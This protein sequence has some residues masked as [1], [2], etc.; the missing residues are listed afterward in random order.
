M[1]I[2]VWRPAI[3]ESIDGR[4]LAQSVSELF[5]DFP[6]ERLP[7]NKFMAFFMRPE[8]MVVMLIFYLVSKPLLKRIA[9]LIDPKA[10]WLRTLIAI[11]NLGLAIFSA[12]VVWN[13]WPAVFFHLAEEGW[14]S[15]YCDRT[16]T[17]WGT[18]GFG[19]WAIVFYISKYYEFLD[20][21]ILVLKGKEPSF[22]QVY[23]HTGIAFTMWGGVLSQSSWLVYVVLFNS[24]IHTFM[25]T[26]FFIKTISPKTEIKAAKY[27]TMA[28]IGQFFTGIALSSGVVV[29]GETCSVFASTRFMVR[30]IH[31]YAYGLIALF[32]SF[33]SRKYKKKP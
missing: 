5:F 30:L 23:H 3:S 16:G 24:V 11:H 15:T 14:F 6:Y 20:T 4:P 2:G 13:A 8:C 21:W 22:L 27:L 1:M 18:S 10:I 31:V 33:A 19:A 32:I 25:Y 26:Y 17:L 28:Q 9:K 7:E 12:V 29:M